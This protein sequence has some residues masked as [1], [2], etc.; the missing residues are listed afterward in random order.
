M[1]E[2]DLVAA[3]Q[4]VELERDARVAQVQGAVMGQGSDECQDCGEIIEPARRKAA[5]FAVRCVQC[6]SAAERQMRV[7]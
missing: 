5:P 4:A 2:R 6:Q 3:E 7:M 1:D